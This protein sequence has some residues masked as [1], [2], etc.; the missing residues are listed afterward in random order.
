MKRMTI[1]EARDLLKQRGFTLKWT[2]DD[3]R[4]CPKGEAE[5]VAYYTDDLEDALWTAKNW[6][7]ASPTQ[8]LS[9]DSPSL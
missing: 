8:T 7:G 4:L 2:G 3:Y 5:G 6:N 9:S 1:K